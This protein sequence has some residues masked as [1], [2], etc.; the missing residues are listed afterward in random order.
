MQIR[1]CGCVVGLWVC[2]C[3]LVGNESV[4]ILQEEDKGAQLL[5]GALGAEAAEV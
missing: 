4:G 2:G 1:D 5:D 3:A